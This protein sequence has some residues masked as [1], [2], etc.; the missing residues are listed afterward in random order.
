MP[1][2]DAL[3]VIAQLADKLARDMPRNLE[4]AQL[5]FLIDALKTAQPPP[6]KRDDLA[7][8]R[9]AKVE[10]VINL[11][12]AK[13]LGLTFPITLLGRTDEVIECGTQEVRPSRPGG[14]ANWGAAEIAGGAGLP[15]PP[16][17][18]QSRTSTCQKP[19]ARHRRSQVRAPS[20]GYA[21]EAEAQLLP[22]WR[23]LARAVEPPRR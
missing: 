15:R 16:A 17:A 2:V 11:K 20:Q 6:R 10:L 1:A 21:L 5:R 19:S 3:T 8:E 14:S 12:T 9:S 4:L 7:V 18:D 23:V 22:G 13:M